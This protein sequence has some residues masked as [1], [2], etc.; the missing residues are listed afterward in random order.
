[1]DCTTCGGQLLILPKETVALDGYEA[2]FDVT[3]CRGCGS[4][5]F[6]RYET[7]FPVPAPGPSPEFVAEVQGF[8]PEAPPR[9]AAP[10]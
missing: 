7:H 6:T 3:A 1:M 8:A 4:L 5:S 9:L 2:H 10:P